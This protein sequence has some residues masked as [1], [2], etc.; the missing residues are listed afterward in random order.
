MVYE[1]GKKMI[2]DLITLRPSKSDRIKMLCYTF[3]VVTFAAPGVG[4]SQVPADSGTVEKS[5]TSQI[6]RKIPFIMTSLGFGGTTL[7]VSNFNSQLAVMNGGRGSATINHH[8][9]VGGGGYGISNRIEVESSIPDTFLS[10]GMGYG[11][12]ELGYLL[13]PDY[14]RANLGISF[15]FA[16]GA[17][18]I[19]SIP[20]RRKNSFSIFPVFEPALY[21]ELVLS[22]LIHFQAG[23][24]YRL[25][26]GSDLDYVPDES[27][28]G[29]S[30]YINLLFGTCDC[31]HSDDNSKTK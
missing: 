12:L 18:F 5:D 15:L 25:V 14:K 6:R 29:I 20:K 1:K 2:Q 19:E 24:T 9:T 17:G 10:I 4:L 30:G 31:D 23:V 11:G 27:M 16:A 3:I 21:G 13:F 8:F 28:R 22:R 7:K 26:V